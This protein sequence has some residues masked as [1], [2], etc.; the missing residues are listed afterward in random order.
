MIPRDPQAGIT[1]IAARLS[2]E[3]FR[4][5]QEALGQCWTF[6]GFEW[7]VSQPNDWF[8]TMLG[9]RSII[10]QRFEKGISAFENKCAHRGFP[11]R[12]EDKGSGPL[13]CGF[14]H[15]RYNA[16][17]LALG[18]PE[19]P[20]MF[21]TTPR[22][23]DARLNRVEIAQAGPMLFGRFAGGP[24]VS[25]EEWMGPGLPI[26]RHL[27]GQV[28]PSKAI[29]ERVVKANWRYMIDISLDDYHI[30]AV[31]PSTFGKD[32]YLKPENVHY[33]RFGAHSAYLPGGEPGALAAMAEAC[34]RG[35]Y[36]PHRYRIFQF[37]P[38]LIFA[39]VKI[40]DAFGDTYWALTVQRLV[41][42]AH[43]R[44]RS[45]S[46]F[47]PLAPKPEGKSH[48]ALQR[49]LTWPGMMAG[50]KYYGAKVHEEDNEACEKLQAS[51]RL[52]DPAPYFAKHEERISW[53]D[54]TYR[55]IL[56]GEMPRA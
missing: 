45:I 33:A 2:P 43:D 10:V 39:I 20:A 54:E 30:V 55:A 41:P 46:T 13:I 29:Y 44:T 28:S 18:I 11:L 3:A 16:E 47:F 31:H 38:T 50:F 4:A 52:D 21:D 22:D 14:H 5:E 12:H 40:A 56:S 49:K 51:A 42:E 1:G 27:A 23:L 9:G 48:K 26:L 35:D 19:C 8:R 37:F 24:D 34:A 6:L 7:Q 36:V 32:G 15:W 25:F 17:G 53:F